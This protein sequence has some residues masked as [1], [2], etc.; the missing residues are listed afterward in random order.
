MNMEKLLIYL[1]VFRIILDEV[2]DIIRRCSNKH[3]G[4]EKEAICKK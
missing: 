4:E 2:S 1:L 3:S